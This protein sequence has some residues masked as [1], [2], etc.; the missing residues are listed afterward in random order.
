MKS[1]QRNLP[2]MRGFLHE[3]LPTPQ[4][5]DWSLVI[6]G[7][8]LQ[9]LNSMLACRS[10]G[11]SRARV[12]RAARERW[13]AGSVCR[14]KF[15]LAPPAP[16]TITI[17]RIGPRRLDSDNLAASAKHVRDGI[18]DWLEID[19]GDERLTWNYAQASDGR[20]RYAVGIRLQSSGGEERVE[21][22][23]SSRAVAAPCSARSSGRT[24]TRGRP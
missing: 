13:I 7:L 24:W 15:G 9:S 11:A 18:A 3:N 5:I 4:A 20:G 19:D 21:P 23:R 12:A 8:K 17:T 14:S 22:A 1:T 10:L 6:P 16:L 2:G